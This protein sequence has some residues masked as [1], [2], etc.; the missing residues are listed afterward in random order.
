M[1]VWSLFIISLMGLFFYNKRDS[2]IPTAVLPTTEIIEPI[3]RRSEAE[4]CLRFFACA[5]SNHVEMCS[6]HFCFYIGTDFCSVFTNVK[7][8]GIF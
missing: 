6:C 5:F 4:L 7:N 3:K 8:K 2:I 1:M